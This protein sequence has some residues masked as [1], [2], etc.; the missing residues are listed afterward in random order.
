MTIP[1]NENCVHLAQSLSHK[2]GITD[3]SFLTPNRTSHGYEC[4]ITH[5]TYDSCQDL[6]NTGTGELAA[7][8]LYRV[9]GVDC[10][11]TIIAKE[12]FVHDKNIF[13]RLDRT[14]IGL[15][16][17]RE[18]VQVY[19]SHQGA[20]MSPINVVSYVDSADQEPQLGSASN[21]WMPRHQISEI[22]L[23]EGLSDAFASTVMRDCEVSTALHGNNGGTHRL[24]LGP[25][26]LA[27]AVLCREDFNPFL[28]NQSEI[29]QVSG[30]FVEIESSSVDTIIRPQLAPRALGLRV[31]INRFS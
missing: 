15:I 2:L 21:K 23:F 7:L 12:D 27:L 14:C 9:T 17:S 24:W 18:D 16:F 1:R 6:Q 4:T 10:A 20:R 19:E 28:Y 5:K 30:P 31:N 11:D 3:L 8:H 25:E 22:E 13:L 29:Q 26:A